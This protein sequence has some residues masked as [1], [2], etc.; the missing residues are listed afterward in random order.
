MST[1]TVT[2]ESTCIKNLFGGPIL[3]SSRPNDSKAGLDSEVWQA[4]A[5]YKSLANQVLGTASKHQLDS[6]R[7]VQ[8]RSAQHAPTLRWY[9]TNHASLRDLQISRIFDEISL[10]NPSDV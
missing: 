5:D 7:S 9:V 1:P 8:T 6:M 3:Q 2:W 10:H 4:L